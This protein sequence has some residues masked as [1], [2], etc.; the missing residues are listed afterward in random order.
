MLEI[1]ALQLWW[2]LLQAASRYGNGFSCVCCCCCQ[3]IHGVLWGLYPESG[4]ADCACAPHM[5]EVCRR[6]LLHPEERCRWRA[7]GAPQQPS[8]GHSVPSWGRKRWFSTTSGHSTP[9]EGRW[10]PKHHSV[11]EAHAH[12]LLSGLSIPPPSPCQ[13][14]SGQMPVW[15]NQDQ[16]QLTG[17]SCTRRAQ[18][19]HGPKAEWL[20]WCL[21][22]LIYL[23]TAHPGRRWPRSGTGG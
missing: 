8:T 16:Q 5:E 1:H 6:H 13:E 7:P 23:A 19:H 14:R 21:Y 18:H 20:P 9:E 17:Q 22:L 12:C 2:R 3:P 4:P 15:Q 11:Q 10:Q